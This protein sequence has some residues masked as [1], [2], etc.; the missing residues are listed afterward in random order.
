MQSLETASQ[1]LM[2]ASKY[3]RDGVRDSGDDVRITILKTNTPYPSRKIWRICACTH[4]RPRGIKLNT[5]YPEDQYAVLEIWYVNILEDIKRGPY[6][7]KPQYAVSNPLDTPSIKIDAMNKGKSEKGSI[8][9][10]FNW[11]EELVSSMMKGSLSLKHSWLSLKMNYLLEGLTLGQTLNSSYQNE[12]TKLSLENE[13]M[14]DEISDLKKV[15]KKCNS[16]RVTLDQ[17]LTK[18]LHGNIVRALGEKGRRKEKISSKKV[19]FTKSNVST[20]ETSP[21]TP[22]DSE[23]KGNTQRPLHSLPKLMGVEPSGNTKCLSFPKTKQTTEK[24]VP[25]NVKR[26]TKTKSAH[27]SPTEKLLLTLIQEVKG[28]KEQIQ[29]HSKTSLPTS[30]SGSS[31]SAKGKSKI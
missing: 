16:S 15:I 19:V 11:D 10:S 24:V 3:P 13:S 14:K 29:T 28:L 1:N 4:Q 17:L 9:E 5:P 8:V 25:V 6:S 31:R 30:Q 20:S 23:S 27:D 18:Q 12:I 26:K 7:K 21:E 22:S 2:T